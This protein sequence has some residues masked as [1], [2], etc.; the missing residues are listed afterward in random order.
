MSVLS[1]SWRRM[2]AGI[3]SGKF[4]PGAPGLAFETWASRGLHRSGTGC[5]DPVGRGF[6]PGKNS[7]LRTWN[8]MYSA[9]LKHL[10]LPQNARYLPLTCR[11]FTIL[12][13][14]VGLQMPLFR[15][16]THPPIKN[17][18]PFPHFVHQDVHLFVAFQADFPKLRS[19]KS[20]A[21]RFESLVPQSLVPVPRTW[22]TSGCGIRS[23]A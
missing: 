19:N 5:C 20:P 17:P 21:Q 7:F 23:G 11:S 10:L 9:A 2:T 18:T 12:R 15:P 22:A 6:I 4:W 3:S 16:P 8:I 14:P 13:T 1:M